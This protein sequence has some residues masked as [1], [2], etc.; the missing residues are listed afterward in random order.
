MR[1]ILILLLLQG[2]LWGRVIID[3]NNITA[4]ELQINNCPPSTS[5]FVSTWKTDNTGTSTDYQITL[6]LESSGTYDFDVDWGD[7]ICET[8][9]EY[10]QAE[11]THTYFAI[12]TYEV[13]IDGVING[14]AFNN[15]GD[16][17]KI[18]EISQWGD[19]LVGDNGEYF[20]GCTNLNISATDCLDTTNMT[21]FASFFQRCESLTSINVSGW[22]T[23]LV[24]DMAHMFRECFLLTS[25]DLSSWD[26]ENVSIM[27]SMFYR[28]YNLTEINFTGWNTI[29]LTNLGGSFQQCTSLTELGVDGFDM[30]SVTNV[31]AMLKLSTI[32]NYSD[33]LISW[34]AQAVQPNLSFNGG[35]STYSD[36][37]ETARDI[38]T[39]LPNNWTIT[40]GGHE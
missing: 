26:V 28:S 4:G 23:S 38:L 10:D 16:K 19:L 34:A 1:K 2:F 24:D 37:G 14:W 8:I 39:G 9:T 15:T 21:D 13:Q 11:V 5:G 20:Q 18:I 31:A 27:G 32:T 12:G 29:S 6:P 35:N 7:G 22:D 40:D 30:T 25:L 36:A 17:T 3:N 33:I